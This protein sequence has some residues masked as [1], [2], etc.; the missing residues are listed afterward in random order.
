MKKGFAGLRVLSFESRR[1]REIEELIRKQ[2][3]RA[4][5][6]PAVREAPIESSPE[7]EKFTEELVAGRLDGVIFLTGVGTKALLEAAARM[8]PRE[9]LR[10]ALSR[11]P[12]VARSGKP[13]AALREAGIPVALTAPEPNTSREVLQVLDQK[14]GVSPLAGRRVAV[15][16]YG[17]ESREL[18]EGLQARGAEALAV[19]VYEWARPEDQGPLR[20]AVQAV[21]GGEIDVALFTASVQ[22]A[23]LL[24]AADEMGAGK[25]LRE[26]FAKVVV[27]SI[28]P[29]T[30]AELR[31]HGIGVD[32]EPTHP[33][34]GFLVQEAAEKSGEILRRKR[35]NVKF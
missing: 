21:V 1:G 32:L 29:V 25:Q 5:V 14:P 16:E 23:H 28:G 13:A 24:E 22:L 35:G 15:Q 18:M 9:E 8:K 31:R 11:I 19:R 3:G 7:I 6:A 12:V 10:A 4:T 26:A 33:K 30:S 17:A 20:R 27:G 34:M 2:G